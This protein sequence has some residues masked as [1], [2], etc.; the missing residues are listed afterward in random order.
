MPTLTRDH[1]NVAV[2]STCQMLFGTGRSLIV[3]TSPL[4]G[5]AIAADKSL[6]TLPHALVIVGTALLTLPAALLMRRFGR[7]NGFVIGGVIGALGGVVCM[8][9][10]LIADFW[11]FAL[12]TLLFGASAGFAQHYRFAVTDVASV[13][14]RSKAIS[15]VLAAGVVSGFAGPEI[16]KLS[17][18]LFLPTL[19]L[20]PYLFLILITLLSSI[21]VM[22]VDI[23]N[24][25][26]KEAAE[27]G[28]P[29]REIMRQP[30]FIVAVMAATIGQG[31]MNLLM[32]ATPLAMQ[33]AHHPFDDTAFV[34][35]W[36]SICMFAP[37]FITGSLIKRWGE[38]KIIMTGL[39]LLALCVPIALAGDTVFLFWTSMA[40][41]GVG[42]NFAFTA[43]TSL[44]ADAHTPSERAKT[45]GWV[46]F[47]IY[48][49]AAVAALSAGQLLHYF[50]WAVVNYVALPMVAL[51]IV[52]TLYFAWMQKS[53][54]PAQG[55]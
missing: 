7:K 5:Y 8:Y 22:F 23:P 9:G 3:A 55:E 21:V 46:N 35:Q 6:A 17:K 31:V 12:G 34:I 16:A 14:F 2:L 13:A 53:A 50:S 51:A 29:M 11:M 25:T 48:G 47:I 19:F 15:W 37:G 28:R 36:H 54:R 44:L 40:L 10:V 45:Q 39:I 18:D 30:V 32:T 38:I 52:V 4:I 24:L 41:L 27:P 1:R 26:P 49:T 42:W 43:G 20:G 33:H